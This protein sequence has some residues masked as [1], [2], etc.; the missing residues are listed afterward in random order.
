MTLDE[1]DWQARQVSAFIQAKPIRTS[2]N[3]PHLVST[4]G[5]GRV[6]GDLE[7]VPSQLFRIMNFKRRLTLEYEFSKDAEEVRNIHY[8]LICERSADVEEGDWFTYIDAEYE[9]KFI[10]RKQEDRLVAG[11]VVRGAAQ[12]D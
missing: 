11:V 8:L 3:R 4:P 2:L 9:V 5:G 6:Q 10:S 1:S 12:E 7:T